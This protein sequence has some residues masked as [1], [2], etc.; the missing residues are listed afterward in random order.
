MQ[1]ILLSPFYQVA[2]S[3][4]GGKHLKRMLNVGND[5]QDS[6]QESQGESV[7]DEQALYVPVHHSPSLETRQGVM[8]K[9]E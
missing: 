4:F 6:V 3:Q 1:Q 9:A 7:T 2:D 8:K 5:A